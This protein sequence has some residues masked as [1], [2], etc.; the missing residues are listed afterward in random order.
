[1]RFGWGLKDST[2]MKRAR[3][4]RKRARRKGFGLEE[5]EEEEEAPLEAIDWLV[6]VL[7]TC[8]IL[9]IS[10]SFEGSEHLY[11]KGFN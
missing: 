10:K 4:R 7:L 2:R 5:E 11:S 8:Y 1:M 3:E 6:F 9:R